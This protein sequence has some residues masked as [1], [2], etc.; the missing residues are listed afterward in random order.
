M[1]D[2]N[3]WNSVRDGQYKGGDRRCSQMNPGSV[4]RMGTVDIEF[5][6]DRVR[7]T[8]AAVF[9]SMTDGAVVAS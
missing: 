9:V 3:G 4:C 6:A 1:H 2:A 7:G 8:Q 5:G